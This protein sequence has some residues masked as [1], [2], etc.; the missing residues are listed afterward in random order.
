MCSSDLY[1]ALDK[2]VQITS[3]FGNGSAAVWA[4]SLTA[5]APDTNILMTYAPSSGWLAGKPAA[6]SHVYG[7]G[8][9]TYIGAT[10]DPALLRATVDPLMSAAGVRPVLSHIPPGVELMERSADRGARIWILINHGTSAQH[11]EL[12]PGA[13]EMLSGNAV[14]SID[15]PAHGVAV[16]SPERSR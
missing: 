1:Y 5:T 11:V 12:P 16:V 4:E 15:L 13:I 8:E 7:R 2:P 9:I 10:L 3:A 14:G 6:L